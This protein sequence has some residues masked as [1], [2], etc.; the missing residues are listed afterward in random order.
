MEPP[1]HV[2]Q[3]EDQVDLRSYSTPQEA[4]KN[5]DYELIHSITSHS[6]SSAQKCENLF[7]RQK[8]EIGGWESMLLR[9]RSECEFGGV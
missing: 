8:Y 7:A 2:G 1:H 5:N 3:R 6:L 4:Y 9:R